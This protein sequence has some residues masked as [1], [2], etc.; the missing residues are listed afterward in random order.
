MPTFTAS[1]TTGQELHGSSTVTNGSSATDD[2]NLASAGYYEI[3]IQIDLDIAAG[4]PNGNVTIEV[5]SSVDGGSNDSTV[6]LTTRTVAFTTTGTKK[7]PIVGI[8]GSY[9]AV[10]VTNGTGVDLTYV[11][12][13][14]GLKQASA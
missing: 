1:W 4:S 3:D 8:R 7:V 6:P 11:G 14:A 10:K 13:Y 9:V 12:R 5:F 2:V